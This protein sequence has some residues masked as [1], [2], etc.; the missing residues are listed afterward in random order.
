MCNDGPVAS[1][2][3]LLLALSLH[4]GNALPKLCMHTPPDLR[5]GLP[6]E[7]AFLSDLQ[8]ERERRNTPWLRSL[9]V[10]AWDDDSRDH[11]RHCAD[12]A[13]AA[14]DGGV[15][16]YPDLECILHGPW[17]FARP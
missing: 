15:L 9:S 3:A 16:Q 8:K 4:A 13:M 11:G 2:D 14:K 6:E 10:S 12:T 1:T 17:T 5:Q 7:S